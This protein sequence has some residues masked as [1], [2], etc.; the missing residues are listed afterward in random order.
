MDVIAM[1]LMSIITIQNQLITKKVKRKYIITYFCVALISI[2]E[3][4]SLKIDGI[5]PEYREL[6]IWLTTFGF[7]VAPL[8]P[9]TLGSAIYSFQY[10]KIIRIIWAIYFGMI[11]ISLPFGWIFEV[12]AMNV[13]SRGPYFMVYIAMYAISAIYYMILMI[14]AAEKYQHHSEKTIVLLGVCFFFESSIQVFNP[15]VQLSWMAITLLIIINYI[16]FNTLW[17]QMDGLTRLLNQQ[18]YMK[19]CEDNRKNGVML[20]MDVD[21]FKKINDQYGHNVGNEVLVKI[22]DIIK[23]VYGKQ[24][25][26]YRVGGDEFLVLLHAKINYHELNDIFYQKIEMEKAKADYFPDVSVGSVPFS[27]DDN[28]QDIFNIADHKM[29]EH[30][31]K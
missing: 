25:M 15:N 6:N 21:R 23:A 1:F 28:L 29:Y 20:F 11:L 31:I 9:I 8:I 2:S 16:Y 14:H 17:Q 30:K 13:Y 5:Y 27:K 4:V 22:A 24:G 12:N 3:L 18:S 19:A 7:G 10:E 26:C